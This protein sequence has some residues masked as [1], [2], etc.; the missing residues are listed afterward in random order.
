MKLHA[1]IRRL[2]A[3]LLGFRKPTPANVAVRRL[4]E[5]RRDQ[6]R[7][8][9]D[10]TPPS[11]RDHG[12][13]RSEAGFEAGFEGLRAGSLFIPFSELK[14]SAQPRIPPQAGKPEVRPAEFMKGDLSSERDPR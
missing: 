4:R 14:G 12:Q 9:W 11:S 2:F 1:A 5:L 6:G 3:R 10:V 8:R 13:D 7:R